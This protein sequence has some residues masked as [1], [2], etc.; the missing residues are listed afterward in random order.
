VT[1]HEEVTYVTVRCGRCQNEQEARASA[2]TT[3]C[4]ECGRTC[5][6]TVPADGPNVIPF[7]RTA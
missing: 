6:L 3:R 7:R 5:S 4:R 1:Y 2:R